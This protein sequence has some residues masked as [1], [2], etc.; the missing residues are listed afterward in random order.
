MTDSRRRRWLGSAWYEDKVYRRVVQALLVANAVAA[1]VLVVL[2]ARDGNPEPPPLAGSGSGAALAPAESRSPS[3]APAVS[4]TASPAPSA[5][6]SPAPSV[7]ASPTP[8]P[9]PGATSAPDAEEPTFLTPPDEFRPV[10]DDVAGTGPLTVDDVVRLDG[11][12]P[13]RARDR[14]TELGFVD[15]RSRAWQSPTDSLLVVAYRFR[16]QQGAETYV[17]EANALRRRDPAV[18]GVGLSLVPGGDAFRLQVPGDPTQVAFVSRGSVAYVVGLVGP[19]ADDPEG[20]L[21]QLLA[22]RQ[23]ADAAA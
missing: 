19:G 22:A 10:P 13:T 6:A 4:M 1:V 18:T 14:F 5:T 11:S 12:D 9:A 7:T 15:A 17:R 20:Q 2:L 8:A 23:Y 16:D 3:L 21:L